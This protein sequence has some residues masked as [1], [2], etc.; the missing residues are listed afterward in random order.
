[1]FQ[2]NL[3]QFIYFKNCSNAR[4]ELSINMHSIKYKA[5]MNAQNCNSLVG[6]L[7]VIIHISE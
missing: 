6:D 5:S 4:E 3:M 2:S 1:M 7:R